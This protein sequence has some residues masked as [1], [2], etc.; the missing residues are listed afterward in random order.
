MLVGYLY[1]Y[2][3]VIWKVFHHPFLKSF[4][5][6]GTGVVHNRFSAMPINQAHKQTNVDRALRAHI[7][8]VNLLHMNTILAGQQNRWGR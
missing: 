3:Y 1:S 5:H 7:P 4:R 2:M 6:V 8:H